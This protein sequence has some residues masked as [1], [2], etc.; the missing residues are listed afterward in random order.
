MSGSPR[1]PRPLSPSTL[2]VWGGE[3]T[4]FADSR[5]EVPAD[6]RAACEYVGRAAS[7]AVRVFEEKV[8]LLERAEAATSFATGMAAVSTTL[9]ELLSPGDRLVSVR[10][11][12]GGTNRLFF[13]VLPRVEV[14]VDLRDTGDQL[15]LEESIG[16]GC[17]MVYLET[18][19]NPTLVVLD[20][21]RLADAAH[22]AGALLLVD[23]TCATP[24]NQR[25]LSLGADLVLHSAG[26]ELCGHADVSGGA[27]CG[28]R[29]LVERV[30]RYREITGAALEPVAAHLLIRGMQTLGV[31][32]RQRNVSAQ[33][34]AHW[35]QEQPA[36]AAVYYPGLESH[37]GHGIAVRQMSGF[38][39]V[40]N[41]QLAGGAEAVGRVLPELRLA[42]RAAP[43]G[44]A[45]TTV[46]LPA[47]TSCVEWPV[48]QR[49]AIGIPQG[50]VRYSVG[51]E[52]AAD[53][54][55]DLEQALAAA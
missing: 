5:V 39:S 21:A 1:Q 10:D 47:A 12:C 7:T 45:G 13:D 42:Q 18:P 46:G 4:S 14:R 52:D 40:M 33:R 15:R 27:L 3:G 35:L 36:V 34:I 31:R 49:A 32:V 44:A 20:I 30:N 23:N 26:I 41:L 29:E 19:T 43:P 53:L 2:A 38:G 11:M 55:A 48:E 51:I 17:S 24:V 6:H 25:P 9:F 8:R 22:R 54:I 16:E 28:R 50:L 37:P